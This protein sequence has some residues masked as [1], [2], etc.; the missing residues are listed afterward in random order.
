MKLIKNILSG[1]F[2]NAYGTMAKCNIERFVSI[3][4]DISKLLTAL[5][6]PNTLYNKLHSLKN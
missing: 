2:R 6:K 3:S 1:V 5:C 4:N